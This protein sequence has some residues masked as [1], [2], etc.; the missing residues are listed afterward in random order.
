MGA[1]VKKYARKVNANWC[2]VVSTEVFGQRVVVK[3]G[4]SRGSEI[5]FKVTASMSIYTASRL[6]VDLRKALRQIRAESAAAL[7]AQV[8]I[9]EKPL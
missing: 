2:P 4:E 6:I 1:R 8:A 7:D 5:K 9:A 3:T